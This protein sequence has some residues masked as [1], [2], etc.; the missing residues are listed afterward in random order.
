MDLSEWI[1]RHARLTPERTA[2]RFPGRD[3]SYAAS[4]RLCALDKAR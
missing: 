2:I 3:V 1:D 4:I